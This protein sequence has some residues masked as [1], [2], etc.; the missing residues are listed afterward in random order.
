MVITYRDVK[1]K[2]NLQSNP[3]LNLPICAHQYENSAPLLP[4]EVLLNE[5]RFPLSLCGSVILQLGAQQLFCQAL[6]LLVTLRV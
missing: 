5:I 4:S 2:M 6:L 1:G 3:C